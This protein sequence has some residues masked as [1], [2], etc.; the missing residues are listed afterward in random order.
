[1]S[2]SAFGVIAFSALLGTIGAPVRCLPWL[3]LFPV[4]RTKPG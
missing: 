3:I 4:I 2:S 1:M